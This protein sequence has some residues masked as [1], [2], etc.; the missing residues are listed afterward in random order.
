MKQ[1]EFIRLRA[2]SRKWLRESVKISNKAQREAKNAGQSH[3]VSGTGDEGWRTN[4]ED[5]AQAETLRGAAY[6]LNNL[7]LALRHQLRVTK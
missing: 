1:S 6:E 7:L 4:I 2:L 5:F 3:D